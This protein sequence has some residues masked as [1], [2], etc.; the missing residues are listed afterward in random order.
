MTAARTGPL[1]PH[2]AGALERPGR[3]RA[4][5]TRPRARPPPRAKCADSSARLRFCRDAAEPATSPPGEFLRGP[6]GL[7]LPQWPRRQQG[8]AAAVP[9]ALFGKQKPQRARSV[10]GPAVVLPC[11]AHEVARSTAPT[12]EHTGLGASTGAEARRGSLVLLFTPTAPGQR[13]E[14]LQAPLLCLGSRCP[15]HGHDITPP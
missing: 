4:T 1:G 8:A 15:V 9:A 14:A 11:R 10:G 5:S 13:K 3:P 2:G 12:A 7:V 6:P